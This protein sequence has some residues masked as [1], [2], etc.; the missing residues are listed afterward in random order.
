MHVGT[1]V[2]VI[3]LVAYVQI[4]PLEIAS[5]VAPGRRTSPAYL[6]TLREFYR[7]PS[8]VVFRVPV[9]GESAEDPPEGFFTCYEAFLTCCR[10]WFP[11]PEAIVRALDRF[12]LSISQL[13]VMALQN[14]L[15]VLILS[16]ENGPQPRRL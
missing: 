5:F 7:V 8:G 11:I 1:S 9:H 2:R 3:G 16:Y 12:E 15:G 10:M 6:K 4:D 13:N 14:F